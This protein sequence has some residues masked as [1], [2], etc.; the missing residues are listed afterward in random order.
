MSHIA[1]PII[2]LG[3]AYLN[4]NK[5][6]NFSDIDDNSDNLELKLDL[7]ENNKNFLKYKNNLFNVKN[8]VAKSKFTL[9][10]EEDVYQ[11]QDRFFK[12]K[13]FSFKPIKELQNNKEYKKKEKEYYTL[14][15]EYNNIDTTLSLLDQYN[16][17]DTIFSREYK[18]I[19]TRLKSMNKNTQEYT[20]LKNRLKVLENKNKNKYKST[21][22][23]KEEAAVSLEKLENEMSELINTNYTSL[24][25]DNV[26]TSFFKH[27]NSNLYFSSKSY[28]N[29]SSGSYASVLEKTTGV[30]EHLL[31]KKEA[32]A[33]FESLKEDV[34]GNKNNNDFY[35]S[36][37]VESNNKANV[38]PFKEKSDQEGVNGFN[39]G[40][41]N[42]DTLLPKSVDELRTTNNP[43][44]SYENDYTTP[45]YNPKQET[46]H[47]D[48]IGLFTKE[49]KDNNTLYDPKNIGHA[50][51]VDKPMNYSEQLINEQN[52][53]TTTTPYFGTMGTIDD[54][55]GYYEKG[56][57][58]HNL[59]QLLPAE[60]FL[61]NTNSTFLPETIKNDY[62]ISSITN[63]NTNR[64]QSEDYFG[65]LKGIIH[66]NILNPI[67]KTLRH[68]KKTN[69]QDSNTFLNIKS[70]QN[71]INPNKTI[72]N[73]GI[74]NRQTNDNK[75]HL[76]VQNQDSSGYQNANPYLVDNQR[77][78]LHKE[79]YGNA[80]GIKKLKSYDAQYKQ[81]NKEHIY[82]SRSASG[83]SK[84]FNNKVN[85][86]LPDKT[87][88]NKNPYV[89]SKSNQ[90]I[91][92]VEH[93]G[94][95]NRG[96]QKYDNI[97]TNYND[98]DLLQAFK[99]NPYT[100]SLQSH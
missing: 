10:N 24:T 31:K 72:Q 38:N 17:I 18:T 46:P 64:D 61:L 41:E 20:E 59:K 13:Q 93:T 67:Q 54:N 12:Q 60:P 96:P 39:W 65:S 97:Q 5:K 7:S 82:S 21:L 55:K 80:I 52:R 1:I 75:M 51:G 28:G 19:I 36:R 23:K 90:N 99:N 95:S 68:S 53:E 48:N 77:Y 83:N 40:M 35:K 86:D 4:S 78:E 88:E 57:T 56:E 44:I 92:S 32:A 27:N 34:Y 22:L 62:G 71:L 43:K 89:I 37:V 70:E 66:N 33:F 15:D 2:L 100:H 91:I 49:T 98:D 45:K 50:T 74:T 81:E 14:L 9:N 3:I 94:S 16:K 26:S 63:K 73:I 84:N 8:N 58:T 79:S 11:Y 87:Y 42:R 29:D 47:L 30:K 25:G 85:F 76:N 69:H 6:E